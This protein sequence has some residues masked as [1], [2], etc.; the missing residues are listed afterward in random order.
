MLAYDENN[1]LCEYEESTY[2][3]A[4]SN[5]HKL[6]NQSISEQIPGFRERESDICPYCGCENGSSM[7][8]DYSNSVL[9]TEELKHL[10][11]KSLFKTVIDYCHRKY[12]ESKCNKCDHHLCCPGIPQGNCKQCLKEIHY[13]NDYPYGRKDYKCDRMMN[14]YVCDYISK[15]ASEILYLMRQS[16]A[17][18]QINDY[19]VLSIGCGACP[20]L[21]ALERYCH[22]NSA[23]KTISYLG[24]DVNELWKSIHEQIDSYKTS[25]IK[26]TRF[27]YKDAVTE[28]F[29]ISDTNIVILQYVIS[30]FYNTGQIGQVQVFFRKL[31]DSIICHKQDGLPMVILIN[32]VNSINRGRDY[33]KDLVSALKEADF[34]GS[35]KCFYFDY[36]IVH[37][38]QRYGERHESNQTIFELPQEFNDIYQPWSDCSS[39]QILIEVQ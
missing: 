17:M 32:D 25:T 11:K 14:F 36:K 20:D 27:K 28:D 26:K 10:K 3:V 16:E 9:G 18:I 6:Y 5:C 19:H 38:A 15:Y 22:E 7:S 12:N 4:C 1:L 37:D 23:Y 30:H 33:F 8:Y 35:Y 39:A 21:I 29:T 34:H 13:P 31:I 24:I 2:I